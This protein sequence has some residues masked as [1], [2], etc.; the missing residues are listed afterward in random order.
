[1]EIQVGNKTLEVTLLSKEGNQV[2]VEIDGKVYDVDVA[3]LQNGTCSLIY[4]GNS[5]NAEL[6]RESGEKHYRV[7]LNYSTYQIDMLDSQAKYMKMRRGGSSDSVQADMIAAPMPCKIVN[8]YVQ[9]GDTLKAGD[10]V[11]TMEAMKMQSNYKVNADCT[12]K[13]VLVNVGDNVRVE[14]PLIK[15]DLKKEER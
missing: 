6:I 4:D 11:L 10:T 13:E 1:M 5:Y 3:M 2:S 7:N 8:I 15:L 14:Q 9:S 12:V